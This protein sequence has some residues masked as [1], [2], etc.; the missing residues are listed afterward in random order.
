MVEVQQRP[1]QPTPAVGIPKHRHHIGEVV[2]RN[3][4]APAV[5]VE[6][7]RVAAAKRTVRDK[8][9]RFYGEFS[10]KMRSDPQKRR[11]LYSVDHVEPGNRFSNV[12]RVVVKSTL[13][14]PGTIEPNLSG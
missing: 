10:A 11:F 13:R 3:A 4:K 7:A 2:G 6:Q 1:F 8:F 9:R 5:P 12:V 14:Q